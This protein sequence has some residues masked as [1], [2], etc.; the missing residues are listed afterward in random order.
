MGRVYLA[1]YKGRKDG[2]G[3]KVWF[4]RSA[5]WVIRVVTGS[6]YS[7]C[8]IAVQHPRD[9]LFDCY[10]ASARDG[11]VRVKTMPLPADKWD[12]IP[13]PD[14]VAASVSRL[15]RRTNGAGYDWPGVF[16]VVFSTPDSKRRWFCSEWCAAAIGRPFPQRYTPAK[17]A[18]WAKYFLLL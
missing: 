7:H 13:L 12:L 4:S 16:G 3:L 10:S 2:R 11:G 18:A 5:D 17:L 8:E 9:N 14:A 6:L 1:M 15:F